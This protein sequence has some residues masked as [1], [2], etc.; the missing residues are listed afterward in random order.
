[1]SEEELRPMNSWWEGTSYVSPPK[2]LTI[3]KALYYDFMM[4]DRKRKPFYPFLVQRGLTN[5]I[6]QQVS[7]LPVIPALASSSNTTTSIV[8]NEDLL[9]ESL[10]Q[11]LAQ[12]AQEA[13]VLDKIETRV[14][15]LENLFKKNGLNNN[16]FTPKTSDQ[17]DANIGLLVSNITAGR[18]YDCSTDAIM[19]AIM[20]GRF[21]EYLS[22]QNKEQMMRICGPVPVA[23]AAAAAAAAATESAPQKEEKGFLKTLFG[24]GGRKMKHSKK[25]SKKR[26]KKFSKKRS[27]KRRRS[28]KRSKSNKKYKGGYKV[29]L[30]VAP[31][32]IGS[33]EGKYTNLDGQQLTSNPTGGIV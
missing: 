23:A 28:I 13:V 33:I 10:Q 16:L 32:Y 6:I 15:F 29:M 31:Q 17:I 14:F 19:S 7:A 20:N 9:H 18:T 3:K 25:R 30:N 11:F 1:M 4:Y 24:L 5:N 12:E 26:S 27:N 21:D 22:E 8:K 2:D